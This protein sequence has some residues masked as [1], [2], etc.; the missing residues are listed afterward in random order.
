MAF[1]SFYIHHKAKRQIV[2]KDKSTFYELL[3]ELNQLQTNRS[4]WFEESLEFL[5]VTKVY[6]KDEALENFLSLIV[7]IFFEQQF[8]ICSLHKEIR[9]EPK[10][11]Y[12][13]IPAGLA[14]LFSY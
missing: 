1:E 13:V 11:L 4:K 8:S 6:P 10:T 2:I 3:Y 5:L 12:A 9:V 7:S 14:S